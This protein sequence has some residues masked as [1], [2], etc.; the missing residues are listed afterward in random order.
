[1]Q[2]ARSGAPTEVGEYP[3][4]ITEIE[5]SASVT[6]EHTFFIDDDDPLREGFEL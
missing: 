5:A 3:A 4:I 6:G 2:G 1:M